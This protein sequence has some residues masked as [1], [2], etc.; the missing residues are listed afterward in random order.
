VGN[1]EDWITRI[2]G[3]L[4]LDDIFKELSEQRYCYEKT[5]HAVALTEWLIE[6][7]PEGLDEVTKLIEEILDNSD[8]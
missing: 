4:V 8:E 2:H 1:E 5:A 3:A 6:N 7:A